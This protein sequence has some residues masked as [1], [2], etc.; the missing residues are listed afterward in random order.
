MTTQGADTR[1]TTGDEVAVRTTA[2]AHGVVGLAG[3]AKGLT[4]AGDPGR[5]LIHLVSRTRQ[6]RRLGSQQLHSACVDGVGSG[7]TGIQGLDHCATGSQQI[8]GSMGASR[9]SA[10][11]RATA[12]RD[13]TSNGEYIT[14]GFKCHRASIA[15]GRVG[16]GVCRRARRDD[17]AHRQTPVCCGACGGQADR[18]ARCTRRRTARVDRAAAAVDGRRRDTDVCTTRGDTG[19]VHSADRQHVLGR[20]LHIACSVRGKHIHHVDRHTG[21]CQVQGKRTRTRQ[22]Q[23]I[24]INATGLDDGT[25][26]RNGTQHHATRRADAVDHQVFGIGKAAD[27]G[28]ATGFHR[29]RII[30]NTQ[31]QDAD[32]VGRCGQ[33]NIGASVVQRFNVQRV[34]QHRAGAED[35]GVGGDGPLGRQIDRTRGFETCHRHAILVTVGDGGR[36][37]VGAIVGTAEQLE[38]VDVVARV[39]Q[40]DDAIL[41]GCH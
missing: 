19:R 14:T 35:G 23:A 7:G 38:L 41:G 11:A 34:G 28:R 3:I 29:V 27:G 18:T 32:V 17:V 13:G 15:T 16:A 30:A 10:V 25:V 31:I 6:A 4:S 9:A 20:E 26:R 36:A 33:L 37:D 8:H 2:T 39:G 5:Q 1:H 12:R 22:C 21:V 40:R 24:G